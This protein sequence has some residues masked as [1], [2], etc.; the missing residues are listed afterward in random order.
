MSLWRLSRRAGFLV[1][2]AILLFSATNA[3]AASAPM[4]PAQLA[5]YQ[6]G[7]KGDRLLFY[8]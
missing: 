6:R 1:S 8:W 4:S 3:L 7:R 5:L 2:I